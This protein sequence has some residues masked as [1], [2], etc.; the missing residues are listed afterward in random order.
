MGRI[1]RLVVAICL[2][3]AA[4]FIVQPAATAS[5]LT[6]NPPPSPMTATVTVPFSYQFTAIGGIAPYT[7]SVKPPPG[8]DLTL[9]LSLS[10]DG[11][12]SGTPTAPGT[13]IFTV[14]VIDGTSAADEVDVTMNVGT[15]PLTLGPPPPSPIPALVDVFHP[16][17]TT[18]GTPPY[19]YHRLGDLPTGMTVDDDSGV[20]LGFPHDVGTFNFTVGVEDSIGEKHGPFAFTL[21]VVPPAIVSPTPGSPIY[22]GQAFSHT[23]ATT[24]ATLVMPTLSLLTG[25]L[26]PGLSLAPNGVLA[27]TPTTIGTFPFTVRATW[28][29]GRASFTADQAVT[30]DVA[31]PP[32][33]APTTSP[34]ASPTDPPTVSPSGPPNPSELPATGSSVGLLV[35]VGMLM[36][37]AGLA[38]TW[39]VR[40]RRD[41]AA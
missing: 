41:T 29:A 24:P 9:G 27:G 2:A 12:L 34:T 17:T 40:R 3:A 13:W 6:I 4:V 22:T 10:G 28:V 23:F 21:V 39:P 26:P 18:G 19:T 36:I 5:S 25:S 35:G 7:F 31:V 38:F 15:L 32:A 14:I 20:L 30:L 16:F 8:G 33:P 11:L 37:V 1:W